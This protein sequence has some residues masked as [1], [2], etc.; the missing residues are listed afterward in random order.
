MAPIV[1]TIEIARPPDEVFAFITDPTAFARWQR[2]VVGVRMLDDG[3]FATTRRVGGTERTMTQAVTRNDPPRS[4]SVRG[5]DG[6]IRP[7]AD[8]T[9]EPVDGGSASR[10]T[11]SLDFEGHGIGVPLV[12]LVRRQA[13]KGAPVSY[14]DLKRLLE[15]R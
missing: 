14:R 11:F 9:I 15:D 8:V 5:V 3:R 10:V 1:S 2:D 13:A 12:S 7:H 4:W 6:P